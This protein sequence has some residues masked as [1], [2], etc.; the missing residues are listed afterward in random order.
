MKSSKNANI[1]P[2]NSIK[3]LTYNIIH[4]LKA[5]DLYS[6]MSFSAPINGK[7]QCCCSLHCN[8]YRHLRTWHIYNA[9][10]TLYKDRSRVVELF[11]MENKQQSMQNNV[12]TQHRHI[13]IRCSLVVCVIY[14]LPYM[15]ITL[16]LH[17]E[18]TGIHDEA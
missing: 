18:S 9:G 14:S 15:Y 17:R 16:N 2:W 8:E 11:Q 10:K 12:E 7:S 1:W 4:V 6:Y 3:T 5:E 13:C